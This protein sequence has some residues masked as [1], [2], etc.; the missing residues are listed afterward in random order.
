[1]ET[2]YRPVLRLK[3]R[4]ARR[5]SIAALAALG[6]GYL[7][8]AVLADPPR[9]LFVALGLLKI[10]GLVGAIALFIDSTGQHAN[11]PDRL[12]DERQRHE[13]DRAYVL[14]YQVIVVS[15]FA[16]FLY[17][18]PAQALGWW[19]PQI[20]PAIDLLSAFAITSLALPGIILAWRGVESD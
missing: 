6:I 9:W 19:L 2:A 15:M 12:L 18:I 17:T 7:G 3:L 20:A 14:S 11:A 1:M 8:S 4:T 13:R 5:L 10:F 16:A